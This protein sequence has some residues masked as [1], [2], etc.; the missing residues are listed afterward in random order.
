MDFSLFNGLG[1]MLRPRK[2]DLYCLIKRLSV[3][4]KRNDEGVFVF[5][6]DYSVFR[7]GLLKDAVKGKSWNEIERMKYHLM[8][9]FEQDK[10]IVG[11]CMEGC[12][13]TAPEGFYCCFFVLLR[14]EFR[15]AVYNELI[16]CFDKSYNVGLA[17]KPLSCLEG[18]ARAEYNS[19]VLKLLLNAVF[20]DYRRAGLED[21]FSCGGDNVLIVKE[22]KKGDMLMSLRFEIDK[23]CDIC[24]SVKTYCRRSVFL[25]CRSSL[26]KLSYGEVLSLPLFRRVEDTLRYEHGEVEPED[27]FVY[28]QR[29]LSRDHKNRYR[30][31]VRLKVRED[32]ADLADWETLVERCKT[33]FL[34]KIVQAMGDMFSEYVTLSFQSVKLDFSFDGASLKTRTANVR[35]SFFDSIGSGTKVVIVNRLDSVDVNVRFVSVLVDSF[36]SF[37]EGSGVE[38]TVAQND[39]PERGALNV[40][41]VHEEDAYE[42]VEDRYISDAEGFAVQH[43]T[44]ETMKEFEERSSKGSVFRKHSPNEGGASLP[45]HPLVY[46]LL[47]ELLVKR[48][49]V[50]ERFSFPLPEDMKDDGKA[51]TIVWRKIF[52]EKVKG[53][54]KTEKHVLYFILQIKEGEMSFHAGKLRDLFDGR[55]SSFVG[56][57]YLRKGLR[58][59]DE[60]KSYDPGSYV[61][62]DGDSLLLIDKAPFTVMCDYG[63]IVGYLVGGKGLRSSEARDSCFAGYYGFSSFVLDGERYFMAGLM[64]DALAGT[65][66]LQTS[67]QPRRVRRLAGDG[68][69]AEKRLFSLMDTVF[70]YRDRFGV[71]PV[72]YKYLMEEYRSWCLREGRSFIEMEEKSSDSEEDGEDGEG[73]CDGL[74]FDSP[75]QVFQKEKGSRVLGFNVGVERR[76]QV[77]AMAR[78]TGLGNKTNFLNLFFFLFMPVYMRLLGVGSGNWNPIGIG[79]KEFVILERIKKS[80]LYKDLSKVIQDPPAE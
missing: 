62:S 55:G 27:T 58:N 32:G 14:E 8:S 56:A 3:D 15:V 1:S 47:R 38:V 26:T 28:I 24:A 54:K 6:K 76:K 19:V 80:D 78:L 45:V 69:N 42:D 17:F 73:D 70:L 12:N 31:F 39:Q 44:V 74:L 66:N 63:R 10:R 11:V 51:Y 2:E 67:V 46:V 21:A 53:Q 72:I 50:E 65:E 4:F 57:D 43:V 60:I 35:G 64:P 7:V 33:S 34:N 79:S 52:R 22:E 68:K 16:G 77:E 20:R 23:Y 41:L 25:K 18:T 71:N 49:I 40:V 5:E 30:E 37:L 48:D 9:F 36:K 59:W 13:V 75:V 29:S 61:F